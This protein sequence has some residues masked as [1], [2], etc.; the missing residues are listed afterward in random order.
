[1]DS[2][3]N[4][5]ID[6]K[7]YYSVDDIRTTAR[8]FAGSARNAREMVRQRRVP[9]DAYIYIR[10]QPGSTTYKKTDGSASQDR[11]YFT[12]AF[13]KTIAELNPT[14]TRVQVTT[15]TPRV[16]KATSEETIEQEKAPD[17]IE[18]DDD[19]KF[20]DEEGNV[21]EIETRGERTHDGIYFRV[22]DVAIAFGIESLKDALIHP[23]SGYKRNTDY[24]VFACRSAVNY[25]RRTT[26]TASAKKCLFLTYQGQLRVLFVTRNNKTGNF[27]KWATETLFT[28]QM[29]T[30]EQKHKLASKITGIPYDSIQ[31][32][33]SA[34]AMPIPCIY[35]I[36]LNDVKTLRP[37]M[38]IPLTFADDMIV[39]KYGQTI[40]FED[41]KNSH[42]QDFKII[43]DHVH[44]KLVQ[45][46][47]IDPK[48]V[49][50]AESALEKLITPHRYI[51]P[52][53][54]KKYDEIIII[55]KRELVDVKKHY[56]TIGTQF[57]GNNDQ[58]NRLLQE[59]THQMDILNERVDARDMV[60][61]ELRKSLQDKDDMIAMLKDEVARLKADEAP[62]KNQKVSSQDH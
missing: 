40:N 48:F 47:Y 44:M 42:R 29:G 27:V 39:F 10:K 33:F 9:S 20:R 28:V 6:S 21:L 4:I 45:F 12:E 13:T 43:K 22:K 61:H 14:G 15:S 52:M 18:L 37:H 51:C 32:F 1:M 35:L 30:S 59:Q 49:S 34:S 46:S 19:E 31:Q 24:K 53:P 36:H 8:A 41:R 54:H 56:T 55:S 57:S 23:G 50:K 60:V 26:S 2:I 3:A 58:I 16:A 38:K 5:I 11:V 62:K 7:V 17:A 25:S